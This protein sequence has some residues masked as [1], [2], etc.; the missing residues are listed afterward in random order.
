MHTNRQLLYMKRKKKELIWEEQRIAIQNNQ[1][2]ANHRQVWR[3]QEKDLLF[4]LSFFFFFYQLEANY[5]TILQWVL[6]YIDMNQPWIHMYSPSRSPSLL[7][8]TC[9]SKRKKGSCEVLLQSPGWQQFLI[10]WTVAE[11]T[12][13]LPS[14]YWDLNGGA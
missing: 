4:F 13:I 8:R 7:P 2:K 6:S 10:G 9:F 3:A 12:E 14:C 1:T 11:Q 5:F